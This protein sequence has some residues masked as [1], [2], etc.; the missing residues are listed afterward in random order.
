MNDIIDTSV[1]MR[2]AI[3]FWPRNRGMRLVPCMRMENGDAA[4]ISQCETD[5]Y[6]NAHLHAPLHFVPD[7]KSAEQSDLHMLIG[8]TVVTELPAVEYDT[9]DELA[10]LDLAP[11]TKRLLPKTRDS[12]NLAERVM[13]FRLP[14]EVRR[15][16]LP[17]RRVARK[18]GSDPSR[19]LC[20]I[21]SIP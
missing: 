18:G 12:R 15:F 4:K 20:G 13:E 1:S 14:A 2:A 6:V 16:H 3:P 9:A 19:S 7:G 8:R 21:A 5:I 10:A 11:D 17:H